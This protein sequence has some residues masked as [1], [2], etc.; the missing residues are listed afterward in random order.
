M[1]QH[2]TGAKMAQRFSFGNP[3]KPPEN[4]CPRKKTPANG[5][6]SKLTAGGKPQVLFLF[7]YIPRCRFGH[8]FLSSHT[9]PKKRH[10]P[11]GN[12]PICDTEVVDSNPMTE[13]WPQNPPFPTTMPLPC[14]VG[15]RGQI[16]Q[17][18]LLLGVFCVV[19][20][21]TRGSLRPEPSSNVSSTYETRGPFCPTPTHPTHPGRAC[22]QEGRGRQ[23]HPSTRTTMP[24]ANATAPEHTKQHPDQ[25]LQHPTSALAQQPAPLCE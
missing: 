21:R 14:L 11:V 13:K 5:C 2:L 18:G 24:P 16:L 12:D 6:G 1:A 23:L 20:P 4:E 10:C 17:S 25:H 19:K 15:P 8:H 22:L 7:P 3:C 9:F